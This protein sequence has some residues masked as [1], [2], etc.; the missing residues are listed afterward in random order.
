MNEGLFEFTEFEMLDELMAGNFTCPAFATQPRSH[1]QLSPAME[2]KLNAR[3]VSTAAARVLFDKAEWLEYFE[4]HGVTEIRNEPWIRQIERSI[5]QNEMKGRRRY[6]LSTLI[7]A[8]KQKREADGDITVLLPDFSSRGG[9]GK[10]RIDAKVE[11]IIKDVID[12]AVR[13][14]RHIVKKELFVK[15]MCEVSLHNIQYPESKISP[16]SHSTVV[17]RIEELI[18]QIDIDRK[19]MTTRKVQRVHRSNSTPRFDPAIPLLL[20]EYDDVDTNV[21]LINQKYKL[22][23]GRGYLTSGICTGT[24]MLL[25]AS[26]G[27]EHRS[28]ESAM[29]AVHHSLQPK[30]LQHPDFKLCNFG[31]EGYGLQSQILM[32][33]ATYNKSQPMKHQSREMQLK[34]CCVKP[35][36]PTAK[37]KIEH[38]NYL[39]QLFCRE[40]PGWRGLDNDPEAV[41]RGMGSAILDVQSF[42]QLVYKW[43]TGGYMN[44]PGADGF[45]P[46]QRWLAYFTNRSPR[47]RWSANELAVFRLVPMMYN[48]RASGGIR[49]L[50]LTYDNSW[51]S[52]LSSHFGKSESVC[53]YIDRFDLNYIVV[54]H[55]I[56][57]EQQRIPCT[58]SDRYG[59]HMTEYAQKTVLKMCRDKGIKNPSLLDM[60][61]ERDQLS[62]LIEQMSRSSKVSTRKRAEQHSKFVQDGPDGQGHFEQKTVVVEKVITELEE[63]LQALQEI[64][65][66]DEDELV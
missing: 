24:Q 63:R 20:S 46:R 32:D 27:I 23:I 66:G 47:I 35:Y 60:Q 28:F 29:S 4:K 64:E 39:L 53:A 37:E 44:T 33:N 12:R 2:M 36:G 58:T 7:E 11:E 15:A 56:T 54:E 5:A 21:F 51:L 3:R 1:L 59:E 65:L 8:Q 16:P 34:V 38:F 43:I 62:K 30:D 17:R 22:P 55:P 6:E 41:K 61:R 14:K 45:T 57:R 19:L 49:R 13:L 31:W 50:G 9:R 25:G 42:K 40:L 52:K 18:P 26:L 48:F 10:K